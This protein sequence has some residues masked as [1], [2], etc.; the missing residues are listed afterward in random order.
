EKSC[1]QIRGALLA[2]PRNTFAWNEM[3]DLVTE[4]WK[5][6][7]ARV[8]AEIEEPDLGGNEE[9]SDGGPF[10]PGSGL[11]CHNFSKEKHKQTVILTPVVDQKAD[12]GE[13][14]NA[15]RE[16][17]AYDRVNYVVT[18]DV[19]IWF[20]WGGEPCEDLVNI[21]WMLSPVP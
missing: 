13:K 2:L 16:P 18:P 9:P 5:A 14:Q 17:K 6:I 15:E 8:E 20:N 11:C 12:V 1:T 4:I 10:L 21:E 19:T 7:L 3:P